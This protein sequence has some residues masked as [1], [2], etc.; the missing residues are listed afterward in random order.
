MEAILMDKKVYIRP[1]DTLE[2]VYELSDKWKD[3]KEMRADLRTMIRY[4]KKQKYDRLRQEF[5]LEI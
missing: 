2:Y 1:E 4:F 5:N 3:I